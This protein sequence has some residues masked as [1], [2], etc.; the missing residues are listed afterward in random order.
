MAVKIVSKILTSHKK[1]L[2]KNILFHEDMVTLG[3]L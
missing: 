1:D 2:E 3:M